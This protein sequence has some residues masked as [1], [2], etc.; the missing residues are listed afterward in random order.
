MLTFNFLKEGEKFKNKNIIC[1]NHKTYS[2]LETNIYRIK[3]RIFAIY[4]FDEL[5][6]NFLSKCIFK[7]NKFV[8]KDGPEIYEFPKLKCP[9]CKIFV[10]DMVY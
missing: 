10:Y 6:D 5:S 7:K 8:Y 1:E 9:K 4:S 3:N 2:I